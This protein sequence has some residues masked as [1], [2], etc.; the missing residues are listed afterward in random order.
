MFS[1][2]LLFLLTISG[3]VV[4]TVDSLEQIETLS[5]QKYTKRQFAEIEKALACK[6]YKI[7]VMSYNML[8]N[9]FEEK[10]EEENWWKN[11]FSRVVDLIEE[12][13][14]DILG[15]Q[16]LYDEQV[17]DLLSKLG[18]EYVFVS[19][20][21]KIGETN[22]IF[23]KKNRFRLLDRAIWNTPHESQIHISDHLTTIVLQDCKTGK[24]F[25]VMNTHF[26]FT[27]IET[28]ER[29]AEFAGRLASQQKIPVI[30]TGD[31]NTFAARPELYK[32]PF[33]DGDYVNKVLN[34][35]CLHD[36][37]ELSLLGHVGPLSTFT[38]EET[39]TVAFKG[40]G[41]PGIFVDHIYLSKGITVL[42]HAVEP[43]KVD[44]HFPSDH[45]P[46]FADLLIN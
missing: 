17:T 19:R 27:D 2:I 44:G 41:T 45:M 3:S 11:R 35:F 31:L 12:T 46:V 15:V 32:M 42:V 8:F 24:I 40:T 9:L 22:G 23:F 25:S 33:F 29:Q 43:A 39:D 4:S 10:K 6:D 5:R 16:E 14:P 21:P 26:A 13:A 20:D 1:S 28:R 18:D 7:R 34:H 30:F 38:N 36:A 37:R